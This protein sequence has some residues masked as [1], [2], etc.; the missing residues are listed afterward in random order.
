M[1]IYY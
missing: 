1:N